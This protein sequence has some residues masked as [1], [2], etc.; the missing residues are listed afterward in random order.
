M[1]GN[2]SEHTWYLVMES[3]KLLVH[4]SHIRVKGFPVDRLNYCH[5]GLHTLNSLFALT[6][7]RMLC[8][9]IYHL[10]S[11]CFAHCC[12]SVSQCIKE[13]TPLA[14]VAMYGRLANHTSY[15]AR[16]AGF[17]KDWFV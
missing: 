14:L 6:L 8:V 7:K 13:C 4:I 16:G 9:E 2:E 3:L 5:F 15:F 1:T 17:N 10:I 12:A 11:F